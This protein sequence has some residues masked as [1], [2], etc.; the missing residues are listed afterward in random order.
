MLQTGRQY[1]PVLS[2]AT[3]VH[4]SWVSQSSSR[5]KSSVIVEKVRTSFFPGFSKQA[6]NILACT[7]MP[8]QHTYN[9]SM[10]LSFRSRRESLHE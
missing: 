4:P 1:T 9:T 5:S 8:Q 2:I 10:S 6:T 7:S 3:C